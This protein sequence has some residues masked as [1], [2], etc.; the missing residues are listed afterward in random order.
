[1][2]IDT[3]E[4]KLQQFCDETGIW[5]PGKDAPQGFVIN[6][7]ELRMRAFELWSDSI[8]KYDKLKASHDKLVK[9]FEKIKYPIPR[10]IA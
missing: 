3:T 10:I 6:E 2:D 9:E 4:K 8:K 7:Y 1:M 5:P